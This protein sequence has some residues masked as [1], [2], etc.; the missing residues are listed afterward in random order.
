MLLRTGVREMAYGDKR[1]YP[2]ISITVRGYYKV[3]TTWARTV[4]E[5]KAHYLAKHPELSARHVHA[6]LED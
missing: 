2:K 3:S 4:K 6:Y 5:A 1:N